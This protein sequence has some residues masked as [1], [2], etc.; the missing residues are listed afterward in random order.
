MQYSL[1]TQLNI[2]EWPD[3]LKSE[4]WVEQTTFKLHERLSRCLNTLKVTL[5]SRVNRVEQLLTSQPVWK[6]SDRDVGLT[7]QPVARC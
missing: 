3:N 5:D 2:G 1:R 6:H 4:H 7:R